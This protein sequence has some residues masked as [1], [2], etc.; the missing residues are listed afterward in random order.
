[1]LGEKVISRSS[2]YSTVQFLYDFAPSHKSTCTEPILATFG[3][4]EK[5]QPILKVI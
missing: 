2:Y 4:K 1:M 5:C 3:S